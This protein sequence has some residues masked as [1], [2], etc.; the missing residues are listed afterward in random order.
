MSAPTVFF[1]GPR[2]HFFRPLNWQDREACAAVL[3]QLHERVHGPDADYAEALTRELVLEIIQQVIAQPAYRNGALPES[4]AASGIVQPQAER[5]YALNLL[6]AL[7]E[8]GW[9]E[10]YK[11]PINLQPTLKLTRAGKAFA[12]VFAELDNTRHKTRQRNMRSARKALQAFLESRDEDELLDAY[13]FASRVVQ[14]LQDDI[15]YFRLLMQTLIEDTRDA[16][17]PPQAILHEVVCQHPVAHAYLLALYRRVLKVSS[18]ADLRKT[19][20]GLMQQGLGSRA[21]GMFACLA[22]DQD[23]AFGME[24]RKRR[25]AWMSQR[26][27][28]LVPELNS[29]GNLDRSLQLVMGWFQRVGADSLSLALSEALDTRLHHVSVQLDLSRL[30]TSSIEGL[31]L[32]KADLQASLDSCAQEWDEEQQKV[33]VQNKELAH[34]SRRLTELDARLPELTLQVTH[35]SVWFSRFASAASGVATEVQLQ[36][37]AQELGLAEEPVTSTLAS[38]VHNT[39]DNL[40][41]RLKTLRNHIANRKVHR[42][43]GEAKLMPWPPRLLPN[44]CTAKRTRACL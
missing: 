39:A 42:C 24:S 3:R 32:R 7:K 28:A 10:D 23:L 26:L 27:D 18:E 8:H 2:E 13:D 30:D 33:G 20:Q 31:M 15:E 38:W 29:L 14:D 37:E 5:D 43:T 17:L 36:T 6:R 19:P 21:Y 44:G 12:E 1:Q 16:S 4:I 22:S 11:D 35:A 41:D 9:L 40:P 34:M 25:L